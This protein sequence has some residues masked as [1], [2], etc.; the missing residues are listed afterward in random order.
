MRFYGRHQP[1]SRARSLC[2]AD[3]FV[4]GSNQLVGLGEFVGGQPVA[5]LLALFRRRLG[6]SSRISLMLMR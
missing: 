3:S 2:R 5:K 4:D 6:N 1:S